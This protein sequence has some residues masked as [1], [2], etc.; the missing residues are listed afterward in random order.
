[1]QII[2]NSRERKALALNMIKNI[3][4]PDCPIKVT[5]EPYIEG[6]TKE[7]RALFHVLARQYGAAKGYTEGQMKLAIKYVVYGSHTVD[8]GGESIEVPASSERTEDGKLR[9]KADYSELIEHTYRLAAEDGIIL[10]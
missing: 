4:E 10:E 8:I 1:M 9:D 6:H 2:I 5:I 7:Q 3:M